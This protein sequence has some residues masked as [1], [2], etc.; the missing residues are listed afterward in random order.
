MLQHCAWHCTNSGFQSYSMTLP[1][2]GFNVTTLHMTLHKL[3]FSILQYDTAKHCHCQTLVFNVTTLR[4]TLH[5]LW[6]SIL[7]HDTAE[8][9]FSILQYD[10]AELCYCQTLLLPNSG[11]Q[12][13]TTLHMTLPKSG[14]Q[15]YGRT[16]PNSGFH[17]VTTPRMT[18]HKPMVFNLTVGHCRTLPL[19]NSGFNTL[20][21]CAW[22]C[23]NSDF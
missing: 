4:M 1:N 7:Q 11:F 3:W 13:V 20:Q 23:T 18:L 8:L 15:S 21:H 6:F 9:W 10:T 2:S 16:L 19:P 14:F 17:Y 22:H 5:E 12:Y